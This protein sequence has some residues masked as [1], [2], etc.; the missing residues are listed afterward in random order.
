MGI[1]SF[2]K[3]LS[4]L[5]EIHHLET[6]KLSVDLSDMGIGEE[7]IE[8]LRNMMASYKG[9]SLSLKI[10]FDGNTVLLPHFNT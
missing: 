8:I 3:F 2:K 4:T 7:D 5:F 1:T 10:N 9:K 6:L